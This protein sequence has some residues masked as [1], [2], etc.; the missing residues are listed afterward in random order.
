MKYLI[1][2]IIPVRNDRRIAKTLECLRVQTRIDS[3]EILVIDSSSNHELEDIKNKFRKDV[4]WVKYV[5]EDKRKRTTVSQ[6][7][8]GV[9]LA[10]G[11]IIAF[12]DSDCIPAK[13]W[14]HNLTLPMLSGE[15]EYCAG[16][17]KSLNDTSYMDVF[18]EKN[19]VNTYVSYCPNMNSAVNKKLFASIGLYDE[20]NFNYGWDVDFSWRAIENGYKIRF[21]RDAIIFHDWGSVK[22]NIKRNYYYGVAKVKLYLKHKDQVKKIIKD[23]FF[24]VKYPAL[25][26]SLPISII[27]PLFIPLI[28][29]FTIKDVARL[30]S[31]LSTVIYNYSYGWGILF[32]VISNVLK[33]LKYFRLM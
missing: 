13:D 20:K 28:L 11:D 19:S 14:L 8:Y 1:S 7:N 25:I 17:V 4:K 6:I 18:W 31:K 3:Y 16:Y 29:Y 21:V 15:E 9:S 32:G 12:I 10:Q 27:F 24:A 26:L 5:S 22:S 33:S 30:K 2:I 23:D